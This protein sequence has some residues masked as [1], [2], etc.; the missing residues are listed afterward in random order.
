MSRLFLLIGIPI[1]LAGLGGGAA[2]TPTNSG[3]RPGVPMNVFTLYLGEAI[4]SRRDVT[5]QEWQSFR[6]EVVAVALPDGFTVIDANG[7]WMNQVTRRTTSEATK[8]LIAALPDTPD[9]LAA[10]NRIRSA[11]QVRFHQQLVGMTI[12]QAC[13]EF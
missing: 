10:I 11:Y 1:W 9:N 8:I 12:E 5:S 7:A 2:P 4:S 3:P 6:D 13:A